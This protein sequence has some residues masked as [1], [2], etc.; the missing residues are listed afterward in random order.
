[1]TISYLAAF[2]GGALALLSPCGALLLPAFFA[3]ST[4]VGARLAGHVSVFYAGL[5]VILVP[6][7]LGASAIG[8]FFTGHRDT[9]ILVAGII[10]IIFGLM[11]LFGAGFDLQR[12]L[13]QA[14][15]S[16]PSKTVGVTRAFL[17][18]ITSG[19]AGFCA[20][21]I[22]GAVLTLAA[23]SGSVTTGAAL[24]AIYGAGMVFPLIILV[25][26][27]HRSGV[28]SKARGRTF[29]VGNRS[30][31]TTSVLTGALL[32]AVGILFITTNGLNS[33]PE[34]V[35]LETQS[36]L[37]GTVQHLTGTAAQVVG[38]LIV[39]GG[40]LALWY[41]WPRREVSTEATAQDQLSEPSRQGEQR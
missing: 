37:Q 39:A 10:I 25:L 24:M 22:L 17:L 2:A 16:S 31:H 4:G 11:Q 5:L 18:G 8:A 40:A 12:F 9:L 33:L 26:A 38:I 3:S 36:Q 21:P 1:M 15:T 6:L 14:A 19:V 35:S 7:G 23:A 29:T 27:W 20:G 34:L 32:I 13:P 41:W 30:F 28:R